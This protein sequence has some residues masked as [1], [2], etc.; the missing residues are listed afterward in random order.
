MDVEVEQSLGFQD[1]VLADYSA[2]GGEQVNFY[3]AYYA[4]QRKGVSPHSPQ[5]CIPGGGWVIMDL[6]EISVPLAGGQALPAVRALIDKQG[7][8]ALV[9]YWFDQRGRLIGNE[10]LMKW[11][12]LVDSFQRNR[13]DGAL[14]RAVT[15]VLP[16]ESPQV[17]DQRLTQFI[18][19]AQPKM[20][21]F[22][23]H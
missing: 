16:N 13:T 5:V 2:A 21:S 20:A 23:P 1:Y 17:A 12:L 7:Q 4:S 9:Y 18:T 3:V 6:R 22:V 19:L 15:A 8:R 14:V 10:Y 11:Y